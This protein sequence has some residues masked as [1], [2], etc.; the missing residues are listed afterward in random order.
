MKLQREKICSE[1]E[2]L[3]LVEA[4]QASFYRVAYRYVR[5]EEDAKDVVQEAVCKAYV[6]REQLQDPE[7][8]YTWFYRILTNT[9]VSFLR[10]HEHTVAWDDEALTLPD[11]D[12]EE[13]WGDAL[14]VRDALAELEEK[15]RTVIRLK[16][17]ENMTFAEIARTLSRP[18]NSV[19][20]CYYRG[21]NSLKERMQVYGS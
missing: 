21:L 4:R 17:Y 3:Q 20:A 19:K 15:A 2:F 10:K 1:E 18:E 13:R 14:W 12:A 7:K 16:I 9:A 5:N 11:W 8:F 6:A